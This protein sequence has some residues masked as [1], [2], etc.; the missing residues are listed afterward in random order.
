VFYDE[1]D[2]GIMDVDELG[3]SDQ[4]I[5]TS[6]EDITVF[7]DHYGNYTTEVYEDETI[8]IFLTPEAEFYQSVP[9]GGGPQVVE[10]DLSSGYYLADDIDF[11]L[12]FVTEGENVSVE[13]LPSGIAPGFDTHCYVHVENKGSESI[14]EGTISLTHP[15]EL[16][17]TETYP[18]YTSYADNTIIWNYSDLV[19]FD[20]QS[21]HAYFTAD[22]TTEVGIDLQYSAIVEPLA[23]DINTIDNYDTVQ[24]TTVSS[25]DPNHKLVFPNGEG[26]DGLID[27]TTSTLE[28]QID[29]QNTGTAEAHFI[30]IRDT[31]D[32]NLDAQSIQMLAAS[33]NYVLEIEGTNILKWIFN[34]IFLPDSTSD[35]AGSMGQLKFKINI[36]DG[37]DVGTTIENAAAIYFDYNPPVITNTTRSTLTIFEYIPDYADEMEIVLFPNPASEILSIQF[38]YPLQKDVV[39]TISDVTGKIITEQTIT[40]NNTSQILDISFLAQGIYQFNIIESGQLLSSR[41]FEIVR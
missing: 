28:Y 29:F 33:H 19:V 12:Q 18:A 23:T 36:K 22:E 41:K 10:P 38:P 26:E 31:L 2:N 17:L 7:T 20:L 34:D 39:Y 27:A 25:L 40:K 37:T 24:I 8:E 3:V 9:T 35:P 32:N 15:E 4:M 6:I 11:A 13:I 14:E 5:T 1:N 16:T 30:I 21:V